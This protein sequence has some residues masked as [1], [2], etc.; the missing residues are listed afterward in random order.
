MHD[1]IV[2]GEHHEGGVG[3]DAAELA[4]VEGPVA[5]GLPLSERAKVLDY[6]VGLEHPGG[7]RLHQ[8]NTSTPRPTASV[9]MSS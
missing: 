5:N 3:H 9:S 1:V 7:E 6:L 4:R 2:E 8:A